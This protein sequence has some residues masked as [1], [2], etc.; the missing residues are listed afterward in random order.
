MTRPPVENGAILIAGD[1]IAAAGSFDDVRRIDGGASIEDFGDAILLPGLVNAHCH[2]EL[3]RCRAGSA[4]TPEQFVPW[5]LERI[6]QPVESNAERTGATKEGIAESLG[7]GVTTIGDITSFPSETRPVLAASTLSG[8]SFGEVR[9]MARRRELLEPRLAAAVAGDSDDLRA[10]ISPHAP[11]SVEASVYSRCLEMARSQNRPLT[12]HL[13]ESADEAEFLADHSGPLRAL[14]ERIGA[15]DDS[16]RRFSGGPIRFAQSIGLLD[17][18]MTSLAHVNYCDDA[19]LAILAA[20]RASVVY[21]PRTHAYF[22]HPPHRWREML[23]AGINVA[24]GTDSRASS[25]DLNLVEDLRLLHR[26]APEVPAKTIWK[27]ATINGAQALGLQGRVGEISAGCRAN[28]IGFEAT[29]EDPM[30]EILEGYSK[31]R[32]AFVKGKRYEKNV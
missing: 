7:F 25:P 2:L 10:G 17:Y 12:T 5:L 24:V 18:S 14:W 19:E 27:M 9:A 26:I 31:V 23:A 13:A 11:Y 22:G 4:R 16:V 20:G 28:V 32:C 15:W 30:M 6:G 8:V 29:T 3:S 21:C 1:R